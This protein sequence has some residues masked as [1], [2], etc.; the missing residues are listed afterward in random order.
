MVS[1]IMEVHVQEQEAE[2]EEVDQ[3]VE[4]EEQLKLVLADNGRN[5]GSQGRDAEDH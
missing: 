4:G 3:R 1:R 5:G 2:M